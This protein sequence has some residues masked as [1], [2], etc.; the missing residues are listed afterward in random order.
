MLCQCCPLL[1]GRAEEVGVWEGWRGGNRL[2]WRG[3]DKLTNKQTNRGTEGEG[4]G[5]DRE[6]GTERIWMEVTRIDLT[7]SPHPTPPLVLLTGQYNTNYQER[8]FVLEAGK[9]EEEEEEREREREREG[10]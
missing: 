8:F 9:E 2:C 6:W 5:M 3:E 4:G 7:L 10:R 1:L